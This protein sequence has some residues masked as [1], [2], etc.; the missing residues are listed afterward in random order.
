MGDLDED[1]RLMLALREGD[2]SAFDALFRRWA[3][4]L[5][6]YLERMVRNTATAEELVQESF[7]RLYRAR[8]RYQPEAR[9][10]TWLY[11][12]ATRL[13]LNE[14]RRPRHHSPHRSTDDEA[15]G[16]I[17]LRAEQASPDAVAHA[18]RVGDEVERVLASLPERQ[19]AALWLTAVEGQ[20]YAEV[21]AALDTSEKSV[22][23]LVHRA[24][25]ALADRL[26]GAER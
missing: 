8:E 11:T 10:S 19:R 7:L 23:A 3:G 17:A 25:S 9:F 4:P 26:G 22:K 6:R 12:I 13:A 16:A 18:R 14:L 21:A 5:L 1:V 2:E 15:E 20:S 24:R